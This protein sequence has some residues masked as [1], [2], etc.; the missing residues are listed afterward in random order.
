MTQNLHRFNHLLIKRTYSGDVLTNISRRTRRLR[1]APADPT[2]RREVEMTTAAVNNPVPERTYS[3]LVGRTIEACR[4]AQ[5]AA[6][7]AAEG[8]ATGSSPLLNSIREKEKQLD[9]L[10]RE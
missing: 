6:A 1:F 8:I 7:T 10:D 4:V 5:E 9:T 3:H 2:H